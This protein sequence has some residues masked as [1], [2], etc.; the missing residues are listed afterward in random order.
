MDELEDEEH[1]IYL[2]PDGLPTSKLELAVCWLKAPNN[3]LIV[4]ADWK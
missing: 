1:Y 3:P 4:T 2:N